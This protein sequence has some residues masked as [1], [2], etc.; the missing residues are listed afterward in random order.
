M[1]DNGFFIRGDRRE[2]LIRLG[3]HMRGHIAI[4]HNDL[5]DLPEFEAVGMDLLRVVDTMKIAYQLGDLPQGLKP[6]AYR[7]CGVRMR[8]YEDVVKPHSRRVMISW[9]N[10]ALKIT[11]K[12]AHWEIDKE[13][14]RPQKFTSKHNREDYVIINDPL[15]GE[16]R[17][18]H[19]R[20]VESPLH[21]DLSRIITHTDKPIDIDAKT[22][23]DPWK[24]LAELKPDA[25]DYMG[26]VAK[27]I[28]EP[29]IESIVHVP[30]NEALNY[31]CED[32]C[33]TPRVL[34]AL[35][36]R[37]R[38]LSEIVPENDYDQL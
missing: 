31:A 5:Y 6:L 30:D 26:V 17:V 23:Y 25:R 27:E 33:M 19:R 38:K 28:G 7:L 1:P 3:K 4:I 32:A 10:E 29:P 8:A 36:S 18:A 21:K 11:A 22:I 34:V 12:L 15:K 9:M 14:T 35:N 37:C 2:M 24:K 13:Y 16:V 20:R